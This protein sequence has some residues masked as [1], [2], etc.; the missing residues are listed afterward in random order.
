MTFKEGI[1]IKGTLSKKYAEEQILRIFI[2]HP[3][4]RLYKH[5]VYLKQERKGT[6]R[7]DR[8]TVLEHQSS[9]KSAR[10]VNVIYKKIRMKCIL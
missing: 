9:I 1:I 4:N 8:C 6:A 7:I 10:S 5:T 2:F 3:K